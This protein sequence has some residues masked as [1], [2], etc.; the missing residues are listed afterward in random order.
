M[1]ISIFCTVKNGELGYSF[2]FLK[3][4]FPKCIYT[5]KKLIFFVL[6]VLE[7]EFSDFMFF[8][9][10]YVSRSQSH[11]FLGTLKSEVP[12]RTVLLV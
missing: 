1:V 2:L 6:S 12:W 5:G 10:V 8:W 4:K 7:K 11:W 3:S 9:S